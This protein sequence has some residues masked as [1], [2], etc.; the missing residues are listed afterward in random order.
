MDGGDPLKEILL[1]SCS[2]DTICE[3]SQGQEVRGDLLPAASFPLPRP[4]I[5]DR[6]QISAD[7]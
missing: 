4:V 7:I 2:G 5:L 3:K 6:A 1:T